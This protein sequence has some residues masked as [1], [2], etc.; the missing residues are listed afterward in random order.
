[1]LTF[2]LIVAAIYIGPCALV[3]WLVCRSRPHVDDQRT[4]SFSILPPDRWDAYDQHEA[5]RAY[6]THLRDPS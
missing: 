5:H 4:D 3:A 6:E 2:V 1:M